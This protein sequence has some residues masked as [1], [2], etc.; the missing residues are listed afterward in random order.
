MNIPPEPIERRTDSAALLVLVTQVHADVQVF[1]KRLDEQRHSEA[2]ALAEAVSTLMIRS[3]PE[4]DADGHKKIHE[5][6]IQAVEARAEFWKK[7]LFEVSKYGLIGVI[8]WLALK[9]WV[10]FLAGPS[11]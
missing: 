5:A 6:Q 8:G 7:M 1:S 10:A 3:F 9:V 2:L 11:K 4:G